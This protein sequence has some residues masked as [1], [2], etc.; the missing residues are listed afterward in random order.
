MKLINHWMTVISHNF[1]NLFLTVNLISPYQS[2]NLFKNTLI[3]LL[4]L[5][6]KSLFPKFDTAQPL[7]SLNNSIDEKTQ[8]FYYNTT[9]DYY[10]NQNNSIINK[11]S[12]LL[13]ENNHQRHEDSQYVI[14]NYDNEKYLNT[15]DNRNVQWKNNFQSLNQVNENNN[16]TYNYLNNIQEDNNINDSNS[17]DNIN[18]S[19]SDNESFIT[20]KD[21]QSFLTA[22]DNQSFV[23]AKDNQSFVTANDDEFNKDNYLKYFDIDELS[24]EYDNPMNQLPSN[25]VIEPNNDITKKIKIKKIYN[26]LKV[27]DKSNEYDNPLPSNQVIEL[28]NYKNK[29][30]NDK[31]IK[32]HKTDNKVKIKFLKSSYKSSYKSSNKRNQNLVNFLLTFGWLSKIFTKTSEISES[33]KLKKKSFAIIDNVKDFIKQEQS[34]NF[35]LYAIQESYYSLKNLTESIIKK[36]D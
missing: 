14:V 33:Q 2:S 30:N 31:E 21:N 19:N 24:N 4:T 17:I 16:D 9:Y 36:L 18:D 1:L 28:N 5:S 7:L 11:Y 26:K 13:Q 15:F 25:E 23:T 20:A 6:S 29:A 35:M 8:D 12:N 22:K 32:I 27:K 3:T 34:M 10:G